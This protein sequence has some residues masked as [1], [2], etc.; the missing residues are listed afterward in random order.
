[1]KKIILGISSSIS[2]YK[3]CDLIRILVKGG[4]SVHTVVTENALNLVTPLTLETL[5][6]NPVYSDSF[7]RDRREM[8]HIELKRDA[9]LLAVV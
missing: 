2:A 1:M 4:F 5:S 3:A 8:G 7:S 9:A 6:G